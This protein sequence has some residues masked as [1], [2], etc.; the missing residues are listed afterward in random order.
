MSSSYIHK[1]GH[2]K[3]KDR[4][5]REKKEKNAQKT[6]PSLE[7][8]GVKAGSS[9]STLNQTNPIATIDEAVAGSHSQPIPI[10]SP[11]TE[12]VPAVPDHPNE[13]SADF[14]MAHSSSGAPSVKSSEK[15][16]KIVSSQIDEPDKISA[17]AGSGLPTNLVSSKLQSLQVGHLY[18]FDVGSLEENE[19]INPRQVEEVVRRGHSKMPTTFPRDRLNDPFP[20]ALL[21][22]SLPNGEKVERDWLVWSRNKEAFFCLPCRLFSTSTATNRSHLCRPEGFA[23]DLAWK[24]LY[25][26]HM[27]IIMIT[28]NVI[29]IGVAW[30]RKSEII[31]QSIHYCV[32]K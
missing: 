9:S 10:D 24:K 22:K 12:T 5:A 11:T 3:R 6:Q 1:S 23:K 30:K 13:T 31:L 4:E 28:L 14:A 25:E 32:N 19:I 7:H 21:F 18:D 17:A 2:K 27:N 15:T 26:R 16:E 20:V 29:L 8:F